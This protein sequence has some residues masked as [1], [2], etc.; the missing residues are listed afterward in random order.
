MPE[1]KVMIVDDDEVFVEELKELLILCGYNTFAFSD[2]LNAFS[3]LRSINPDIILLDLKM[4][5]ING[6]QFADRLRDSSGAKN[7][8]I[9]AMTGFNMGKQ[10]SNLLAF[11]GIDRCI[12]KPFH[13]LDLVADIESCDETARSSR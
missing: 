13:I 12:R 6:L 4:K 8:P 3:S 1:K 2:G 7:I 11:H 10:Y 9:I 5:G